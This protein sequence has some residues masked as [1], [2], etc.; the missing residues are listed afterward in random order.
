MKQEKNIYTVAINGEEGR[1]AE[2][3]KAEEGRIVE[4]GRIAEEGRNK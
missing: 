3:R 4:E 1:K 2:G